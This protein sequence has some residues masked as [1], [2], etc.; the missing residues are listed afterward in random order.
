MVFIQEESGNENKKVE[1]SPKLAKGLLYPTQKK[2]VTLTV[3]AKRGI[4]YKVKMQKY[5]RL[6]FEWQTSGEPLYYDFHGEPKGD[7]TGF[8]ESFSIATARQA[9]GTMTV[10]FEGV[11]GWYW[12]NTSENEIKVTLNI[13]GH[14]E[15]VGS[16]K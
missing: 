4:E 13:E 3:P 12:K 7:T 1:S 8:F 5:G 2:Q 14:Y 15:I 6:K 9:K 11:H 10:P 16:L